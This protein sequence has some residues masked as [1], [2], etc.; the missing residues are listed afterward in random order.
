VGVGSGIKCGVNLWRARRDITDLH[1]AWEHLLS[2]AEAACR[3]RELAV[4]VSLSGHARTH[5]WLRLMFFVLMA[6]LAAGMHLLMI[7]VTPLE[8]L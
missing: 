7:T 2:P 4:R 5:L 6:W 1:P 8:E 3:R